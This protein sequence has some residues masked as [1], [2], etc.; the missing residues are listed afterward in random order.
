MYVILYVL[1]T[2]N[3]TLTVKF[4]KKFYS[5]KVTITVRYIV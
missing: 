1:R 4:K 5:E 3:A 2:I